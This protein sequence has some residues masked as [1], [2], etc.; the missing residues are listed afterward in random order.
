MEKPLA[1][2]GMA[3]GSQRASV[4]DAGA[5]PLRVLDAIANRPFSAP[6]RSFAVVIII[7]VVSFYLVLL[8]DSCVETVCGSPVP[9]LSA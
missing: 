5:R 8:S 4:R 3:G 7:L 2:L 6:W 1:V 9:Q